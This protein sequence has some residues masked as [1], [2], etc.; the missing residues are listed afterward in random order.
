MVEKL[1]TLYFGRVDGLTDAERSNSGIWPT[2]STAIRRP[3]RQRKKYY[4]GHVTLRDVNLGI[5]PPLR[6]CRIWRWAAA[7]ARKLWMCWPPGPCLTALWGG[8]VQLGAA[9]A[10]GGGQ[11]AHRGVC[12]GVP[13]RAEI[14]LRVRHAVGGSGAEAASLFTLHLRRRPVERR[15]GRISAALPLWTPPGTR[16][17][18]PGGSQRGEPL[19]RRRHSRPAPEREPLDGG[20]VPTGWGGR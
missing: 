16:R 4:E 3:T 8:R 2:C 7:G 18:P 14:R 13:G 20:A 10:A 6:G 19:H 12:Q 11:P 1:T 5:A 17:R 15:E 9:D